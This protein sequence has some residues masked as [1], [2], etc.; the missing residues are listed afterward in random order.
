M[1]R[2]STI[3]ALL[4]SFTTLTFAQEVGIRLGVN[5]NNIRIDGLSDQLT[6]A[7]DF[8]AGFTGGVFADLPLQNGFVFHPE[9]NFTQKGFITKYNTDYSMGV[10]DIPIGASLHTNINYAEVAPL[11]KFEQGNDMAKFYVIA[12]PSLG[13]ATNGTMRARASLILDFNVYTTDIDLSNDFVNRWDLA[14]NVGFG[15]S[16]KAGNGK[17]F[18]DVRYQHSFTSGIT[19]QLLDIDFKNSGIQ[20][21]AGY[22]YQF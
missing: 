20:A 5:A 17:I 15:G 14:G 3:F 12:G 21:S 16:V 7:T 19:N 22:A 4:V 1:K 10:V 6:P 13:Y 8:K 18:A 11:M 9:A 2:L